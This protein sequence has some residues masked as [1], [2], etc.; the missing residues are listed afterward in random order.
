M[1]AQVRH[2]G[3]LVLCSL[4]L[5][6][7]IAAADDGGLTMPERKFVV[8]AAQGNMMEVA[9]GKLAAQRAS[10]PAV[11]E[12]AHRMVT[13][14][15]AASEGLKSL[16][17]SKNVTLPDAVSDDQHTA[18]G[19]LESLNGVDFDKAYAQ[20]MVNDHVED[21]GDFE[22]EVKSGKDP[23]VKAFAQETLPTLRHHL[24]LANRLS[25]QQQKS[26]SPPP[27]S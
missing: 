8:T 6:S 1:R 23:D 2:L 20:L 3:G 16:A 13:D 5:V 26:P 12:F 24:M 17:D 18:L 27:A 15:M 4:T 11:R 21:I 22:K 7:A 14:H 9:A 19:K 10:D 25:G